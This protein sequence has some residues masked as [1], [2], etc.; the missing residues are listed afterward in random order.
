[1]RTDQLIRAMAADTT[2][3][4]PVGAVLPWALLA[5]ALVSAAVAL[6]LLGPRPDLENALMQ[7]GVLAKQAFPV[8]LAVGAF[9]AALRLARPGEAIGRWGLVLAA[10]P[11]LVGAAIA[12]ELALL[13]RPGWMPAMLGQTRAT[14]LTAIPLMSVPI[15]AGTLWALRRGASTRPGVSGG[16]AGLLSGG[17]AAAIYAVHCIEDS[18]LFYA[19]W[20]GLAILLVTVVAA[21]LGR[22]VLRW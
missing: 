1:M 4:R 17:A 6:P 3:T 2:P 14:C 13:P 10:V 7:V 18:P 16:L 22:R 5:G 21:A 9:G 11:L 15:L 20:Y 12:V 19:V 8:L